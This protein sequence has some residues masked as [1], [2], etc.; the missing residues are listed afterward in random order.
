[1]RGSGAQSRQLWRSYNAIFSGEDAA[2]SCR[3]LTL[4]LH[5]AITKA[6]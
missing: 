4:H 1:M 3:A 2:N 5:N 6:R